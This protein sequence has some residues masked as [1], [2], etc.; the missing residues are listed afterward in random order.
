MPGGEAVNVEGGRFKECG[1][2]C[3]SGLILLCLSLQAT[4]QHLFF[5]LYSLY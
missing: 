1:L 3:A 5:F 4:C 2:G